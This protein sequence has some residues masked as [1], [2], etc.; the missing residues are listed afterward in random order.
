VAVRAY[1]WLLRPLYPHYRL[2]RIYVISFHPHILEV[3]EREETFATT[4]DGQ[5]TK[6]A[7]EPRRGERLTKQHRS[8][9][10]TKM[11]YAQSDW[12]A[13]ASR[14]LQ[15]SLLS[16]ESIPRSGTQRY[17]PA[18]CRR[19]PCTKTIRE[20]RS[21][22]RIPRAPR[23]V[24]WAIWTSTCGLEIITSHFKTVLWSIV[25]IPSAFPLALSEWSSSGDF[26]PRRNLIH[27]MMGSICDLDI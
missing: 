8:L 9:E 2:R 15:V 18:C 17:R 6:A 5:D 10:H 16:M 22:P 14:H 21:A 12:P 7:A 27:P 23:G 20:Y 24:M 13:G 19:T 11:A 3:L 25:Q 26:L 4:R 1:V